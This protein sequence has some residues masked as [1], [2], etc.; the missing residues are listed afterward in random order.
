M[1]LAT[2]VE[3]STASSLF[4]SAQFHLNVISQAMLR[5]RPEP[6]DLGYGPFSEFIFHRTYSR[7]G[8]KWWQVI[9]RV[10][11][12]CFSIRKDWYS[13]NDLVWDEEAMQRLAH[14]MA[15]TA[16][17]GHWGPPGRGY[18]A[19]GTDVIA[20]K[21]SMALNNPLVGGTKVIT[22]A[23]IVSIESILDQEVEFL[24]ATG[25]EK[26]TVNCFGRQETQKITFAPHHQ[27]SNALVTEIATP[28]HGWMLAH[29][30]KTHDL[31]VGDVVAGIRNRDI[32]QQNPEYQ[33]GFRHGLVFADGTIAYRYRQSEMINYRVRLCGAKSRYSS[34]FAEQETIADGDPVM[35]IATTTP[36]KELPVGRNADYVAGFIAGWIAGDGTPNGSGNIRLST[37]SDEAVRWLRQHAALGGWFVSGH[38]VESNR[39][40]NYGE[41]SAPLQVVTLRSH[42]IN[43]IVKK[44][45]RGPMKKVYCAYV[46][47]SHAFALASGVYSLNC[48]FCDIKDLGRDVHWAMDGLMMGVGI[49]FSTYFDVLT[50]LR[51]PIPVQERVRIE[52]PAD[53]IIQGTPFSTAYHMA[54]DVWD[55][56]AVEFVI[57]DSREGW[58]DAT[59]LLIDSYQGGPHVTFDY[60]RIRARG[61]DIKGFGGKASGPLPLKKLHRQLRV[62]LNSAAQHPECWSN[63]QLV[64]DIINLVGCCVVAGNVRRSA[65]IALGHP[66]DASFAELKNYDNPKYYYRRRHGWMSNN[67]YI[68][69]ERDQ[70]TKTIPV[71]AEGVRR[72]GEPGFYNLLAVKNFGRLGDRVGTELPSKSRLRPDHAT[73]INPC[74]EV[75]LESYELC[76]LAEW[77]PTRCLIDGQFDQKIALKAAEYAAFY[78]QTVQ[79]LPTHRPE[80]NKVIARNRRTGISLA[81]AAALREITTMTEAIALMEEGYSTIRK[82]NAFWSAQAGVPEAIR[83]TAEK[84]SGTT[85]LMMGIPAGCHWPTAGYIRRAVRLDEDRTDL[86][87]VLNAAGVPHEPDLFSANTEVYYFPIKT[88]FPER[89]RPVEEVSMWEQADMAVTLAQHFVDNAVSITVTFDPLTRAQKT[90][91]IQLLTTQR[92]HVQRDMVHIA[93]TQHFIHRDQTF[94]RLSEQLAEIDRKMQALHARI[95]E[96]DDV[97]RLIASYTGKLKSMSMLPRSGHGYAQ[98]P[99]T[100][101]TQDEYE[102]ERSLMGSFDWSSFQADGVEEVYCAACAVV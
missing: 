69:S 50:G 80:T 47:G 79:L 67:S 70:F 86:R 14:D 82:T 95:P 75:P 59:R 25:W 81:G 97:E 33:D 57:P 43:W 93:S 64:T 29:G 51:Q 44:I 1:V 65:T 89:V 71:I 13:K 85:S 41:R 102:K 90:R 40:T 88:A 26:G 60:H 23:G 37:Q 36:L 30:E 7:Q 35:K 84:P 45:E 15:I 6:W 38:S 58:C 92:E 27:R 48:G 78:T 49:G 21:G 34:L 19:M 9:L 96:G 3:P 99:E 62:I 11:E 16:F 53:D 42:F 12:G 73:G 52:Y 10:I 63:S 76:C 31:H 72:N 87:T 100:A 32:D 68:L 91:Q 22:R 24:T 18:W 20:R 94:A 98:A 5:K 61:T 55:H 83:V 8:E 77:Y 66:D 17:D 4:V 39:V 46:P 101:I 74:G 2:P 28:D 54:M 56:P